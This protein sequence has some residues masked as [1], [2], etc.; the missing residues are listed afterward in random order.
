[1]RTSG[2]ID[3]FFQFNNYANVVIDVVD[4]EK[5]F[6]YNKIKLRKINKH[7]TKTVLNVNAWN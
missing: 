3:F 2:K 1:M 5:T 7:N 6:A 4:I